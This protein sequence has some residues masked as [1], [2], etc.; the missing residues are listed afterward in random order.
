MGVIGQRSTAFSEEDAVVERTI[1]HHG[2]G[3]ADG[4]DAAVHIE[5]VTGELHAVSDKGGIGDGDGTGKV[6]ENCAADFH[7]GAIFDLDRTLVGD[8][9]IIAVLVGAVA[10]HQIVV[11]SKGG[12]FTGDGDIGA[13]QS[14]KLV[15]AADLVDL[16]FDRHIG[17][18]KSQVSGFGIQNIDRHT[19]FERDTAILEDVPE[20]IAVDNAD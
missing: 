5:F 20:T 19:F 12:I 7:I 15:I 13:L 16:T 18:S 14:G 10:D 3:S 2:A 8:G 9:V 4:E 6:D 17:Q 1:N 11:N